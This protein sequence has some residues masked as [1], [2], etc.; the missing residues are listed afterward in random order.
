L[1]DQEAPK[2]KRLRHNFLEYINL[3][4]FEECEEKA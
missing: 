1:I 4:D 3:A 2:E